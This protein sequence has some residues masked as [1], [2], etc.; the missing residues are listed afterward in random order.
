[1]H[2]LR[3]TAAYIMTLM[4]DFKHLQEE[5]IVAQ[6]KAFIKIKLRLN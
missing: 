4:E 2:I 3:L 6:L 5:L 1:M